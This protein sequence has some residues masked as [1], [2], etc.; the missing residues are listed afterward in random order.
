M[1]GRPPKPTN[2]KLLAGT[3]RKGREKPERD[4]EH[5]PAVPPEWMSVSARKVW[6]TMAPERV[7]MGLLTSATAESFA[8]L[9]TYFALFQVSPGGLVPA[10]LTDMRALRT[11]FGFDP[12][13]LAKLGIAT[14]KVKPTNPFGALKNG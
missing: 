3:L 12:S 11:A 8:Q 2:L 14:G 5:A 6:D 1:A 13:A 4:V 10:Q 7:A 9:C